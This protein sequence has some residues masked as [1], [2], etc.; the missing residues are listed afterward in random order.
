MR[1]KIGS[2]RGDSSCGIHCLPPNDGRTAAHS[3]AGT[4]TM[5]DSGAR[6]IVATRPAAS[7]GEGETAN[8]RH[9][10]FETSIVALG[11]SATV[12]GHDTAVRGQGPTQKIGT[13]RRAQ[14]RV[15]ARLSVLYEAPWA[16]FWTLFSACTIAGYRG[17][18]SGHAADGVLE[19]APPL[20]CAGRLAA[21]AR[22]STRPWVDSSEPGM[23][24][25]VWGSGGGSRQR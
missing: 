15:S 2:R 4:R 22:C 5:S 12:R 10:A 11:G 24:H 21:R 23:R 14:A 8:E 6:K 18:Q 16:C 20:L 7:G 17:E 19:V 1:A 25:K 3:S 13:L 9:G